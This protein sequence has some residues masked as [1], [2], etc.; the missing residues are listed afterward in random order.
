[1]IADILHKGEHKDKR[2]IFL[3]TAIKLFLEEIFSE[4]GF[5]E[6]A[7]RIILQAVIFK[8]TVPPKPKQISTRSLYVSCSVASCRFHLEMPKKV[9]H[10]LPKMK[11]SR[12]KSNYREDYKVHYTA[13]YAAF[14]T[15]R[16]Q[17][18]CRYLLKLKGHFKQYQAD[19][20][21]SNNLPCL[22]ESYIYPSSKMWMLKKSK[23]K[24]ISD[25][26]ASG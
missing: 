25:R 5:D 22:P 13:E 7:S 20:V 10:V 16:I 24:E 19:L 18:L 9:F 23:E 11:G 21:D 1:M 15:A 4:N 3:D 8:S 12:D 14:P 26:V 17:Y 2:A 6:N